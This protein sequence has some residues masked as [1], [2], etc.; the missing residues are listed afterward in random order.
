MNH[1][2]LK[3]LSASITTLVFI[4]AAVFCSAAPAETG[5]PQITA[6]A[7]ARFLEQAGFGP[8]AASVAEV[9]SVGFSKWID[10]QISLDSS[11][12]SAIPDPSVNAKGNTS[13]APAQAAFFVNA[14]TGK[15][16]LRQ[17]V[18]FALSQIWVV[19]GIKLKP[20]AIVPYLRL[21]QSDAFAPYDKIMYDVTLSPAMG[22]Y[23]DMVNNNKA[24]PGHSPDENYAREILQLF[25]I[26]LDK[27]DIYGRVIKDSTTGAGIPTYDQDTVEGFA[28][29]FTG[30]TYAPQDGKRSKFPNPANWDAPMVAFESNHDMNPKALLN[31]AKLPANQ[32]AEMDLKGALNNIFQHPNVAPFIS[33]QLIQRLTSSNP[34][35]AYVGRISNVFNQQPRGDMAA[36]VKAILLDPEA[37]QGDN[38]SENAATKLREPVL[39]ISALLRGLHATVAPANGLTNA[40][41]GLGQTLYYSPSV[42]NYFAPGYRVSISD[43]QTYNAPEFQLLS[44][45]T[46][47]SAAD[48]VNTFTYGKVG[49]VA[50][51]LSPYVAMLGGA[52]PASADVLRMVDQLNIDL[53]GG[54]MSST[55]RQ[56][57]A[58]AAAAATTPKAIVQ[59]AVYLIGSSWNYQVER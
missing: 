4:N 59:A 3:R 22:H 43:T 38:G 47:A 19:S 58:L 24:T 56:T 12:W 17:R 44:E 54:R 15:D 7:A 45:A 48:L 25:T 30:W 9:Q 41:A 2:L 42:F 27:L 21:L 57:V 32:T 51:D 34:S 18:A 49:G 20:P 55:M 23:L 29:A 11:Q 52:R 1:W 13:L 46:A 36:V 33:R 14:V 8:T 31:G 5:T 10:A 40:A 26:G 6:M 16:Q 50:V 37:R 35:D 39:W 28:A 53:M